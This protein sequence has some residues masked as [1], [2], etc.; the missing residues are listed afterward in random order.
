MAVPTPLGCGAEI[1][2]V[3]GLG[4]VVGSAAGGVL[5]A[6]APAV[7]VKVLLGVVLIASAVRAFRARP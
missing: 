5:I 4:T 1:L 2:P 6:Y 3:M 7:A